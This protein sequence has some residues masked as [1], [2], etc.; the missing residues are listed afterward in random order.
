MHK[1]VKE[2]GGGQA[3]GKGEEEMRVVANLPCLGLCCTSPPQGP[4]LALDC[5]QPQLSSPFCT[6]Y[7]QYPPSPFKIPRQKFGGGSG[8]PT[9]RPEPLNLS[10]VGRRQLHSYAGVRKL[11][12][13]YSDIIPSTTV[14]FPPCPETQK[15]GARWQILKATPFFM[16]HM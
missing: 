9:L 3:S 7:M 6:G 4:A 2:R 8:L 1:W 15:W 16:S 13:G 5:G 14:R 10:P 12:S 11:L